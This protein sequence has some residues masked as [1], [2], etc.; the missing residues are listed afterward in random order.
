MSSRVFCVQLSTRAGHLN[1]STWQHYHIE[2][3]KF[4]PR[5]GLLVLCT[6]A[7]LLWKLWMDVEVSP[8]RLFPGGWQSSPRL[9][10]FPPPQREATRREHNSREAPKIEKRDECVGTLPLQTAT[11]LTPNTA[12]SIHQ[13]QVSLGASPA[14]YAQGSVRIPT[15]TDDNIHRNAPSQRIPPGAPCWVSDNNIL[16]IL[17]ST[18]SG[19]TLRH[20]IHREGLPT[21]GG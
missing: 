16:H 11:L 12:T 3:I 2:H 13:T 21:Q 8:L 5:R 18:Y 15:N 19:E 14:L 4:T 10:G 20:R 7:L 6:G 1:S 9:C 17:T